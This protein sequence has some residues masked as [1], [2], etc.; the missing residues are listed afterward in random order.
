M[1]VALLDGYLAATDTGGG[2]RA[3]SSGGGAAAVVVSGGAM[4]AAIGAPAS[5]EARRALLADRVV[6][7]GD[8]PHRLAGVAF[9]FDAEGF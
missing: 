8:A 2:G 7:S 9:G 1:Q 6:A 3:L 4:G 5:R